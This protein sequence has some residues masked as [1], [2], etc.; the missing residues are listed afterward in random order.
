MKKSDKSKKN[1]D[2]D[3]RRRLQILP[4][5]GNGLSN[6]VFVDGTYF[7]FAVFQTFLTALFPWSII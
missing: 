4:P 3:S 6:W 2:P 1:K 7:C 5:F